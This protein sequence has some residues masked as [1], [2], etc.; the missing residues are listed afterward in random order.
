[1]ITRELT[2]SPPRAE[3]GQMSRVLVV[4]DEELIREMLVLSLEGEGY[5]TFRFECFR[6]FLELI[7]LPKLH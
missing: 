3:I 5:T 6:N 2:K 4:E 1:M 7:K